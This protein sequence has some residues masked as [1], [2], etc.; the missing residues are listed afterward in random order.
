M[1]V[2]QCERLSF[3]LALDELQK[4]MKNGRFMRAKDA[5]GIFAQNSHDEVEMLNNRFKIY[6]FILIQIVCARV[7]ISP[8][9]ILLSAAM[10]IW[11]GRKR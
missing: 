8:F 11:I 3:H 2:K 5:N 9:L 6:T 1:T 4:W 7:H 10:D